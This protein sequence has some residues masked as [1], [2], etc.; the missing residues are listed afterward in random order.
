MQKETE[1]EL[2]SST[3]DNEEK[4]E[5]TEW[6]ITKKLY[7]HLI[8]KKWYNV[9]THQFSNS[10][11]IADIFG[12]NKSN[13]THEIE[14]KV[15]KSDLMSE[16]K[17]IEYLINWWEWLPQWRWSKYVKH[18]WYLNEVKTDSMDKQNRE[19]LIP[20]Y[21]S[22]AVPTELKEIAWEKL[23]NTPYWIIEIYTIWKFIKIWSVIKQAKKIHKTKISFDVLLKIARRMSYINEKNINKN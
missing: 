9:V 10:F 20:N 15:S 22:F 21:F 14:I 19:H 2:N 1:W 6:N 12:V 23:K 8:W 5:L 11:W 18:Y 17:D 13:Y 4:I 7:W 16:I 3:Y